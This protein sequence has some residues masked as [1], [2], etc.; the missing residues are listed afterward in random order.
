MPES[1]ILSGGAPVKS[2][3][4]IGVQPADLEGIEGRLIVNPAQAILVACEKACGKGDLNPP[5]HPVNVGGVRGQHLCAGLTE[6]KTED[7]C[8]NDQ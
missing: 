6:E 8:N 5:V 2:P 3:D 7:R 1:G 4:V